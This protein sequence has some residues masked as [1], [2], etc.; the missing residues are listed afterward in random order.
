MLDRT[1]TMILLVTT[2]IGMLW[3]SGHTLR[4][5]ILR[6]GQPPKFIELLRWVRGG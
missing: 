4:I 2:T 1:G 6:T 3:P 5:G